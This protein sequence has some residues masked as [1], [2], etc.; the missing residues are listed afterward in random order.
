[1]LRLTGE[2][3]ESRGVQDPIAVALEA[4]AERIGVFGLGSA[5][6]IGGVSSAGR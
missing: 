1:H 4:R 6:R 3:A 2:A 5:S